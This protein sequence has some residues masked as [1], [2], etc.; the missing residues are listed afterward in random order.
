MSTRRTAAT[1]T[2][3]Q[4]Q[5]DQDSPLPH[6]QQQEASGDFLRPAFGTNCKNHRIGSETTGAT[7]SGS[8]TVSNNRTGKTPERENIC[9]LVGNTSQ[10]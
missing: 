1:F 7:T 6:P 4:R 5:S 9:G 3:R 10:S 8:G 2:P